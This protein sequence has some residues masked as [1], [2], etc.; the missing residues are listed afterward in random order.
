MKIGLRNA[1]N[2]SVVSVAVVMT[3]DGDRIARRVRIS[4]GAV[5]PVPLLAN[6]ASQYLT[7]KEISPETI[8]A[9]ANLAAEEIAPISDVRASSWYRKEMARVYSIRALSAAAGLKGV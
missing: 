7:G 4:L 9:S 8:A 5:A 6:A 3:L 1:V 2:V